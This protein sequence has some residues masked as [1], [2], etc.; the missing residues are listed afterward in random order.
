MQWVPSHF[1][2]THDFSALP[3]RYPELCQVIKVTPSIAGNLCRLKLTNRYGKGNLSFSKVVIADNPEFKRGHLL[4]KRANAKILIPQGEV[5]FTDPFAFPVRVGEPLYI[6]MVADRPQEYADFAATYETAITNASLSRQHNFQPPFSCRW[7]SRKGWFSFESLE[8]K[9]AVQPL[10][11][12]IT[13][14]SLVESGMVTSA[15]IQSLNKTNPNQISWLLTGI[16]GNQLLHDAPVEEPLYE[17]FGRACL[18]RYQKSELIP[19]LTIAIIG[20]NDLLLPFYSH[21]IAEQNVH[22]QDIERGLARLRM[23]AKSR[24]SEFVTT[25]IAPLRLF[26]LPQLHPSEELIEQKRRKVNAW[27]RPQSWVIDIA[28]E[29]TNPATG[30]LNRQEDFG[31]HLHW[32]PAGGATVAKMLIPEITE[33]LGINN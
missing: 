30:F 13:G 15:L 11:V 12:E 2:Q 24:G 7:Q 4:S 19:R 23:L 25:T 22:A 33:L 32:S 27:L 31:D 1:Q 26:D 28:S 3:F 14:D 9:T 8:V 29:L 17:T 16:S 18:S 21:I 6:Q 5:V 10:T 20:T